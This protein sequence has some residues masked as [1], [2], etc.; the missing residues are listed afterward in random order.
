MDE[1]RASRPVLY[2]QPGCTESV[3]V[4]AWLNDRSIQFAEKDVVR[5]PDAAAALAATGVFATP[6]LVVETERVLGF[7]PQ[8]LTRLF[9]D[10]DGAV[11]P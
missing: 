3:R 2:I 7:R 1:P 8:E 4:R 11:G 5:D 10:R 9:A 6:L